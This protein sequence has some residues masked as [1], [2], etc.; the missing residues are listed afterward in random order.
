M[1]INFSNIGGGGGGS[2][3]LP[4]ASDTTLGGVKVGSGLTIDASTGVL[5]AEGEETYYLD[6]MTTEEKIALWTKLS[7]HTQDNLNITVIKGDGEDKSRCI[8][9]AQGSGGEIYFT[10]IGRQYPSYWFLQSNGNLNLHHMYNLDDIKTYTAGSG[11]TINNNAISA[12]VDSTMDATSTNP[13]Q[14]NVVKTY[15]DTMV[16]NIESLLAS[17]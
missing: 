12:V 14:N 17:I 11:I 15:V 7:G 16:G 3:T 10:F 2:Y 8:S 4:I 5:S 9:Y 1:V 6:D 13:V